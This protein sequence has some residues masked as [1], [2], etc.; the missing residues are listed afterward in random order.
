[1]TNVVTTLQPELSFF[2]ENKHEW[3][4]HHGDQ[5]VLVKGHESFGFFPLYGDAVN[6]GF[7]RFGNQP[8]LVK[9]VIEKDPVVQF[10]ALTVGAI[11][12][13]FK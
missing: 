4:K 8:F 10:P 11:H 1:M 13:N 12:A 7:R 9:Q 2:N 5:F 3:L 6:E